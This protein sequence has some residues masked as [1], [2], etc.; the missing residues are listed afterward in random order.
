[1]KAYGPTTCLAAGAERGVCILW[2]ITG[3]SWRERRTAAVLPRPYRRCCINAD[4][5]G[6]GGGGGEGRWGVSG[7][8]SCDFFFLSFF[9][10]FTPSARYRK[11]EALSI[12]AQH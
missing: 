6:G 3:D 5:R 7:V 9:F 1:M 10:F 12:G 8:R 11:H 2:N 4:H